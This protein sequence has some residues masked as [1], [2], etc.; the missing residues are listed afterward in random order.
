[1]ME[2]EKKKLVDGLVCRISTVYHLEASAA[3]QALRRSDFYTVL[4]DNQM[5]LWE[6]GIEKN[7][8]RY[9]NEVE[10]G[11]WNRNEH[12]GIAE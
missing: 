5:G 11:A 1:M 7:F 8:Q 6:D 2:A 3:E 9:Q 12:G 10:Y 4:I